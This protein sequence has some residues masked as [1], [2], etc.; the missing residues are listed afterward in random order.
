MPYAVAIDIGGTF[1]AVA[2]ADGNLSSSAGDR[3]SVIAIDAYGDPRPDLLIL[4]DGEGVAYRND[5][6]GAFGR[7][8]NRDGGFGAGLRGAIAADFDNDGD[9]DIFSFGSEG[10]RLWRNSGKGTYTDVTGDSGLGVTS[11]LTAAVAADFDNDGLMDIYLAG[12]EVTA[13]GAAS[14]IKLFRNLG[15]SVFR[16]M[17]AQTGLRAGAAAAADYDM[18]GDLDLFIPG[19]N[20]GGV[21]YRNE[22]GHRN[23]W[24]RV[25]LTGTR[26]NA[27]GMGARVK[28]RPPDLLPRTAWLAGASSFPSQSA[29]ELIVGLGRSVRADVTVAWPS[30]IVDY[31]WDVA[32]NRSM[33]FTEG[34]QAPARW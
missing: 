24:L 15:G 33:T 10:G 29:S 22:I 32:G 1:T 26:S 16:D 3:A 25:K 2:A 19:G 20:R 23:N 14:V 21:L 9:A 11:D 27:G 13:R 6:E 31:F 4:A 28:V 34:V 12:V 8:E 17:T 7:I 18:D 5:G 30:G